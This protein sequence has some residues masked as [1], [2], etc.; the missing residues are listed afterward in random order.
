MAGIVRN[1]SGRCDICYAELPEGQQRFCST[2]CR[3]RWASLSYKKI[4][5]DS[6]MEED[7]VGSDDNSDN[8]EPW[9]YYD[10]G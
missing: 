2:K 7:K 6:S 4:R 1:E 8:G 9:G 3:Q 5:Y 10:E